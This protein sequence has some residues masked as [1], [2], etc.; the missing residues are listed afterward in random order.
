MGSFSG[1][2]SQPRLGQ[3]DWIPAVITTALQSTPAVISAYNAKR[4]AD[5]AK[6]DKERADQNAAAAKANAEATAKA[7]ADAKAKADAV[8]KAQGIDPQAAA[9]NT[10]LGV[11]PAVALSGAGIVLGAG[12]WLV[13]RKR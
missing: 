6:Q 7:E 1:F 13:L 10:I 3:F 5:R 12:L 11:H 2:Q 4:A 8:L 9:S